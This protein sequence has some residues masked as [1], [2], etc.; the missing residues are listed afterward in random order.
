MIVVLFSHWVVSV[1]LQHHRLQPTRLSCPS[2]FPGICS[3]SCPLSP[4]CH[5]TTSSS[6]VPLSSCPQCFPAL[7]FSNESALRI[8]W[9]KF[10]SF[11]FSI[12]PSNEYPGLI[13]F[14]IDSFNLLQSKGLSGVFSSTTVRKH[15]FLGTQPFFWSYSHICTW[16]LER[17]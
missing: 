1:S 5:P 4:W 17:P 15:Q 10:S 14:R 12:S 11:N 6:V 8:R 3:N 2:L 9:P 7:V 16:L 13:S